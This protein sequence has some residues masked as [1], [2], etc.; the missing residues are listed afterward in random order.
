V[1]SFD[2]PDGVYCTGDNSRT[3]DNYYSLDHLRDVVFAA[4]VCDL[5]DGTTGNEGI[6]YFYEAGLGFYDAGLRTGAYGLPDGADVCIT[7]NGLQNWVA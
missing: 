3:V 1:S 5:F 7:V 2:P 4:G 6:S